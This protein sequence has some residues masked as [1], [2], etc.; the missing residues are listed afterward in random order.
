MENE[1]KQRT[2]RNRRRERAQRML[3]QKREN[4]VKNGADSGEDESPTREKPQRPPPPSRRKKSKDPVF[5]EDVIDGFAILSFKT[6]EDLESTVRLCGKGAAETLGRTE[7]LVPKIEPIN[8]VHTRNHNALNN[9]NNNHNNNTANNHHE[10]GPSLPETASSSVAASDETW[11]ERERLPPPR[12]PSHDRLSDASSR[13]SSGRGYICDS[14]GD[15]DK[16]SDGGSILFTP[17]VRKHDLPVLPITNHLPVLN[18]G[19]G[20][21]GSP[22]RG[23]PSPP[24]PAKPAAMAPPPSTAPASPPRPVSPPP[25]AAHVRRSSCDTLRSTLKRR[26]LT[27]FPARWLL[28]FYF[29]DIST[30]LKT[31]S[32]FILTCLDM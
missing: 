24:P 8:N 21:T 30:F 22:G 3:A 10:K 18:N 12:A 16:G 29:K 25:P 20:G 4:K 32:L 11:R 28:I 13:C 2:Q 9:N 19:T 15:D 6:Y 23:S 27:I 1:V 7:D 17:T 31:T 26:L 14:E 5:E